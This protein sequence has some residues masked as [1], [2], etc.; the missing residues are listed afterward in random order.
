MS[1]KKT[2]L[3]FAVKTAFATYGLGLLFC[4]FCAWLSETCAA[5]PLI[6]VL[7]LPVSLAGGIF[8]YQHKRIQNL[9]RQV[10]WLLQERKKDEAPKGAGR[11]PSGRAC[12]T[13]IKE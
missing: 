1:P 12:T 4:G 5:F 7:C 3:S 6:L 13:I 10:N 2:E 11:D 9:E 8:A